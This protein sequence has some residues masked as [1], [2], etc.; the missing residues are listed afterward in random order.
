MISARTAR[1]IGTELSKL[2]WELVPKEESNYDLFKYRKSFN[3]QTA[4][5]CVFSLG[6]EAPPESTPETIARETDTRYSECG[7]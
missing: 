1:L 7:E 5:V 2:G 3:G 6:V 4:T